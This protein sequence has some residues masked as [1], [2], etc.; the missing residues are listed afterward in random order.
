MFSRRRL[1]ITCDMRIE[2]SLRNKRIAN[3]LEDHVPK[4]RNAAN[5]FEQFLILGAPPDFE[6]KPEPTILMSYPPGPSSSRLTDE[7]NLIKNFC[8]PVGFR[9]IPSDVNKVRVILNEFVFYLNE[10]STRIF[11]T[12]LHF[13]AHQNCVFSSS[14]SRKYPFCFC[15]LTLLPYLSSH[16]QFL[17][18]FSL[19][20][21]DRVRSIDHSVPGATPVIEEEKSP[22][23]L[24]SPISGLIADEEFPNI[25]IFPGFKATKQIN[26]E[27][28][29]YYNLPITTKTNIRNGLAVNNPFPPIP[30]SKKM[31]LY[32]PLHLSRQKCLAYSTFHALFSNIMISDVVKIYSAILLEMHVLFVSEF[33]H[34]LTTALIASLS[35]LEPFK[36][37]AT[38]KLPILPTHSEMMELLD[39]P[40]PYV[41]GSCIVNN[42]AD[43]V[44]NLDT[45]KLTLN[46]KVPPIPNQWKLLH[47]LQMIMNDSQK[48]YKIPPREIIDKKTGKKVKN[49]NYLEFITHTDPY[50]FPYV[51]TSLTEVKCI[52]PPYVIDQILDAFAK[53]FAPDL[54]DLIRGCFVTDSTDVFNPVTV[55]N[56]DL[57]MMSCPDA[58]R[59]FYESFLQTEI[60][61]DF[62]DKLAD[63]FADFKK[64]MSMDFSQFIDDEETEGPLSAPNGF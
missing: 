23:L 30:L 33:T 59:S 29:F 14:K 48:D 51:F 17:S 35:L 4:M 52:Y 9:P 26:D 45:G 58:D 54:E 24:A 50:N 21:N 10:G 3:E 1:S 53:A 16:F 34:R 5:M 19:L 44:V 41:I 8:F 40:T 13:Q 25:A 62:C 49:D 55:C 38:M 12:C 7:I 63:E 56:K 36:S 11:G 64:S 42:N 2:K 57:F 43:V 15:F 32:L 6:D 31:D 28:T 60:W 18:Y 46:T 20:I 47:K 61:E 39:S 27:L 37:I 22:S